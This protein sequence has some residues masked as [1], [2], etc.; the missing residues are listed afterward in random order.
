MI[1]QKIQLST[2]MPSDTRH[3]YYI[4]WLWLPHLLKHFQIDN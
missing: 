4:Q 3:L 2:D 1:A